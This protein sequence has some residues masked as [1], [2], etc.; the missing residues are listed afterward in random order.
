[1]LTSRRTIS[2]A[3]QSQN[4]YF[5]LFFVLYFFFSRCDAG[6]DEHKCKCYSLT[7]PLAFLVWVLSGYK[8]WEGRVVSSFL[9]KG[10][11]VPCRGCVIC[12]FSGRRGAAWCR[13]LEV[14]VVRSPRDA[15]TTSNWRLFVPWVSGY[16][17]AIAVYDNMDDGS[18]FIFIR[19]ST[20]YKQR[21]GRS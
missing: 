18:G 17:K 15:V 6:G 7:L 3:N 12:L 13:V 5:T 16:K 10:L 11:D 2:A 20:P 1:M 14:L 21:H 9:N 4:F 19:F 8:Q